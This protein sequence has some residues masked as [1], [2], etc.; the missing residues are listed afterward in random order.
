MDVQGL[1]ARAARYLEPFLRLQGTDPLDGG[2]RSKEGVFHGLPVPGH[3]YQGFRYNLDHGFVLWTLGEHFLLSG[4]GAWMAENADRI[5]AGCDFI[6][7]ERKA[8]AA[9]PGGDRGGI[10]GLVPPGHLEDVAE[11]HRWF[12]VNAHFHL[13][14]KRAGQALRAAGDARGEAVL[15][16]AEAYRKDIARAAAVARERAPVVRL[17]DG[18]AVPMTPARA[19]LRGR[20]VGWIREQLY[21]SIHLLIGEVIDPLSPEGSWIAE[22][23]EDNLFLRPEYG[24]PADLPGYWFSHGGHAVQSNLVPVIRVHLMRGDHEAAVRTLLNNLATNLFEDVRQSTEHPV[25]QFGHG[26]GPFYKS[27]DEGSWVVSMRNALAFERDPE[28]L[29]LLAAAPRE[30]FG[31]GQVISVRDVATWFGPCSV[32][33]EGGK[34]IVRATVRL[35]ERKAPGK[36]VL[37][38]R[39]AAGRPVRE[40][41]AAGAGGEAK[42]LPIADAAGGGIDLSGLRGEVRVEAVFGTIEERRG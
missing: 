4:D 16:D 30:W 35:P 27:S 19:D 21:G 25:E 41:R 20:E 40:A 1:H 29:W 28:T 5:A 38:L 37:F 11:W 26:R 6:V 2:F 9:A 14:L 24:R 17:R 36:L 39:D 3:N 12:A 18:T 23:F 15:A 10:V 22:D 33:V 7:R 32:L 13:G 8:A 34:D 42:A 31:P